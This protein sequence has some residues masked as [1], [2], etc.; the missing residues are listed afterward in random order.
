VL[1]QCIGDNEIIF[2]H[3][4]NPCVTHLVNSV[5]ETSKYEIYRMISL[6]QGSD[7]EMRK[8]CSSRN[9]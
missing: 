6:Y 5:E 4:T 3:M 8:M 2:S 9:E 1:T 7:E